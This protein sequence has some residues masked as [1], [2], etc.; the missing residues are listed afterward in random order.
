MIPRESA[1]PIG[2]IP[3]T[4]DKRNGSMPVSSTEPIS[5]PNESLIAVR[6]EMEGEIESFIKGGNEGK[7]LNL[8]VP[9][10]AGKSHT[11]TQMIN[12]L[13]PMGQDIVWF[14][15]MHDQFG[16][17]DKLRN[18]NWVHLRGRTSGD[19]KTLQNCKH[20]QK[21][22][23]MYNRGVF[24]PGMLCRKECDIQKCE[25]WSKF[26]E[27]GHKFLPHQMLF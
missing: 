16:D 13:F 12:S 11:T 19:G 17:L 3:R 6:K 18:E 7:V 21:A 2:L 26:G 24:V 25:Y 9:A 8:Q 22:R 20:A 27:K 10:G 23:Q 1:K 4:K 15:S 5:A 14:A